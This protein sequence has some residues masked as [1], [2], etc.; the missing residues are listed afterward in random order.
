M[1]KVLVPIA[2]GSEEIEL[3]TIVDVLRRA[4]VEVSVASVMQTR[5]I[6]ASRGV[7]IVADCAIEDCVGQNWDLIAIPGGIPGAEHLSQSECL[8]EILHEQFEK[9]RW[10]AAICAAP[11]VVLGRQQL[12]QSKN[13]T[14]HPAFQEELGGQVKT[15]SKQRVMI[16]GKLITSQA[17][18]TAMEFA[19]TLVECLFG[20][21][22]RDEIAAPMVT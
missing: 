21:S 1:A 8:T 6:T 10:I 16:D 12:I 13:A 7:C 20:K 4:E 3:V 2:D 14:C 18:G 19:L 22:K 9:Q 17:P 5:T 15:V 11:A